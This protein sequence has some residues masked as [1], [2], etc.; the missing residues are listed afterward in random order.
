MKITYYGHSCFS[1][2]INGKHI[3]FDPFIKGNPLAGNIKIDE[4]PADYIFISHA[5]FD[6]IDDLL[7]IATRTKA[8]VVSN[9]EIVSWCIK[10][11]VN[12][13]QPLNPGGKWQFDFGTVKCV[14]AVHS[15]SFTTGENGGVASGFIFRSAQGNFYY[16]GDTALTLDMQLIPKW[17]ELDFAILPIGDDLTMGFEDAAEAASMINVKKVIGVHYDTFKFIEIN[18]DEA[19]SAFQIKDINLQLLKIGSVTDIKTGNESL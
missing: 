1:A 17:A 4:I 12:N 13:T 9:F 6:H 11:G 16:S 15:S 5:H 14:T 19:V 18:K 7:N 2:E 10:N 8:L 3:L